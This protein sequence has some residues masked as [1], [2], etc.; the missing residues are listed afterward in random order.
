MKREYPEIVD[1]EKEPHTVQFLPDC[2][3][4]GELASKV[5]YKFL[6]N[7]QFLLYFV[8]LGIPICRSNFCQNLRG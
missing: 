1:C 7:I 5:A 4:Y 6:P 2:Y 8:I 3:L